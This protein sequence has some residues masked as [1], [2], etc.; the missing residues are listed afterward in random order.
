ML[1]VEVSKLPG[2]MHSHLLEPPISQ[3]SAATPPGTTG[4]AAT[5]VEAST[6]GL[7]ET[8]SGTAVCLWL[9]G[10]HAKRMLIQYFTHF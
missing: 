10:T 9:S 2:L 7:S 8:P 4:L 6:S 1:G 5:G 3:S